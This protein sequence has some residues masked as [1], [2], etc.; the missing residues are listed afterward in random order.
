MPQPDATVVVCTYNRAALLGPA[1]ESLAAMQ[2]GERFQYEVLVV[3]NGSTDDTC[4]VVAEVAGR[5]QVPIRHVCETARGV[6]AARNRGVAEARGSWI[7]F[8]DDDQLAHPDWLAQ[9]LATAHEKNARCVGGAV[10]LALPAGQSRRLA[11]DCRRV[12][13]ATP[14]IDTVCRYT[15]KR[16]P[17]T[18]NLLLHASVFDEV[19]RFDPALQQAGEDVDLFRRIRAAG[20][21]GWFTPH[22]I[23]W[24]VTP[25]Y[26]LTDEYFLWVSL[27]VG[28]AFAHRDRQEKGLAPLAAILAART[29][30]AG[31]LHLPRWL[32][33]RVR[34]DAEG[35]LAMRC[36][37][38]RFEGYARRG[39]QLLVPRLFAQERFFAGLDSRRERQWFACREAAS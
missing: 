10:D 15:R 12:L 23:V 26:R 32:W 7:A 38:A 37:L 36:L 31:L 25:A 39:L 30:Q 29:L 34:G 2:T 16:M 9:L 11:L 5:S 6:A 33:R 3:D 20:I 14:P 18:G 27:R 21:D 8:F 4:A 1:L 19:G 35:L 22:A 13:G 28:A 24:H 17:G